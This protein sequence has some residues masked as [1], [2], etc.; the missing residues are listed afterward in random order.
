MPD[1]LLMVDCQRSV[2]SSDVE[3]CCIRYECC[4]GADGASLGLRRK[5]SGTDGAFNCVVERDTHSDELSPISALSAVH[6]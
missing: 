3:S 4:V 6:R 5:S 2:E 1:E